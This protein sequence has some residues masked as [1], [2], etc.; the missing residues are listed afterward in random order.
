MT[1]PQTAEQKLTVALDTLERQ[2]EE[3]RWQYLTILERNRKLVRL[4]KKHNVRS[5]S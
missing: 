4:L 5:E 3:L 2:Y 1:K